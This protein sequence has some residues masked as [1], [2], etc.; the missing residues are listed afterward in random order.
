[1]EEDVYGRPRTTADL[2]TSTEETWHSDCFESERWL[3]S[4]GNDKAFLEYRARARQSMP[5]RRGVELFCNLSRKPVY[6][7]TALYSY[8][9]T[10]WPARKFSSI[11][12]TERLSKTQS[13]SLLI[14]WMI[15]IMI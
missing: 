14:S 15:S 11:R 1:M 12:E 8:Y 5:S 3:R 7:E 6:D 9:D 4:V 10:Y 13:I 2:T